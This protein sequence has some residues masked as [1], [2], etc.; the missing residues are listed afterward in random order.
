MKRRLSQMLGGCNSLEIVFMVIFP[1]NVKNVYN[2][3]GRDFSELDNILCF[4]HII[5]KSN[6]SL[7]FHQNRFTPLENRSKTNAVTW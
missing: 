5:S 7:L 2:N 1:I 6:G 3:K 4:S